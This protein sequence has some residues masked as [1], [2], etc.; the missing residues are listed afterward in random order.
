MWK[1]S[2]FENYGTVRL[3]ND[4]LSIPGYLEFK[5]DKLHKV[6]L[7]RSHLFAPEMLACLARLFQELS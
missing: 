7:Q 4:V 1:G 6:A 2:P 3:V 5:G